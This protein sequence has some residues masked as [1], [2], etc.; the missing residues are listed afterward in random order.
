LISG[1]AQLAAEARGFKKRKK[2]LVAGVGFEGE[3]VV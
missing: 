2:K 1:V 3:F